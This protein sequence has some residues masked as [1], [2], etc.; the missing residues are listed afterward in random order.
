MSVC[1]EIFEELYNDIKKSNSK[2][3]I[4][5]SWSSININIPSFSGKIRDNKIYAEY[6]EMN[7]ALTEERKHII[8]ARNYG[9]SNRK[10][11]KIIYDNGSRS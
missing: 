10:I 1:L 11:K 4:I 8:L 5:E 3:D 2:E 6:L 7:K 9:I